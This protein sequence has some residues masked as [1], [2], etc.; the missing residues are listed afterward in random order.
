MSRS[1]APH[2][3][4]AIARHTGAQARPAAAQPSSAGG[5]AGYAPHVRK[6]IE[7]RG[8]T[9]APEMGGRSVAAGEFVLY[10][11]KKLGGAPPPPPKRPVY[12]LGCNDK[13][14]G[15]SF[16]SLETGRVAPAGDAYAGFV[17]MSKGGPVYVSP[18]PG[19]GLQGDSH[20]TIASRTPEWQRGRRAVVAAGEVGLLGGAIIGHNDKTGHFQS[21]HNRQQSGMPAERFHSFTQD[22][23][24]WYKP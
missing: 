13:G 9:E 15:C 4:A 11:E 1:P 18:R 8:P 12:T 23:K 14:A 24:D 19:T 6:A 7:R 20:P 10:D 16:T 3:A 17:R 21:R 22:P 5:L 2:V